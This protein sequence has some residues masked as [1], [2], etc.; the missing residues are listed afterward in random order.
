MKFFKTI[1]GSNEEDI[2]DEDLDTQ[3][4]IEMEDEYMKNL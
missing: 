4:D 2:N 1:K 3:Y